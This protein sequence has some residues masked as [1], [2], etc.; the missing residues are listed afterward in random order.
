LTTLIEVLPTHRFDEDRLHA[1]L[2]ERLPGIGRLS[3]RQFQGGQSNPTFLL[4]TAQ[5]RM[6][7][8][9]KP[10]GTLLPSAHQVEREY[11]IIKALHGS[12]IPV[13]RPLLL[14]EDPTIIGTAFYV[15][16]FVQGRVFDSP[17]L[18]ELT[19]SERRTA[20][21][22]LIE[23]IANLH[24]VDW[25]GIGLSDFGRPKDYLLR[26]VDR[27]SRQYKASVV[28]DSDPLIDGVISWLRE[29]MPH[30]NATTIAHGDFRIG[31]LMYEPVSF[32]VTAVLDWELSTLGD[33]ISDLAY[34]CLPYHLPANTEGVKGLRGLDLDALG[35]PT[36]AQVLSRYCQLTGRESVPNWAFYVAFSLF[37][38][39]AIVQG[40]YARAI[41]GNASNADALNV[42]QRISILARTAHAVAYGERY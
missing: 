11:R 13:P 2:G 12:A 38:S 24:H 42:G 36:E 25:A 16:E 20:Y 22:N 34:C 40:V 35:I 9:K 15:M 6:V 14:C 41:Q 1:Y 10:P 39:T 19:A 7:L 23:T 26:Q 21:N 28:G 33:P 32:R 3:I 27:W 29:N 4:E 17:D 30:D 18:H 8:R 31:N 37:R 5:G